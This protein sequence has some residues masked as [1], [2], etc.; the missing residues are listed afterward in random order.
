M[1]ASELN[2]STARVEGPLR[3]K[4]GGWLVRGGAGGARGRQPF[5]V[6]PPPT[7][8]P[9]ARDAARRP[10]PGPIDIW[11]RARALSLGPRP[12]LGARAP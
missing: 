2:L 1:A 4:I 8:L 6:T 5:R 12:A 11:R 3:V 10:A 7:A 9:R